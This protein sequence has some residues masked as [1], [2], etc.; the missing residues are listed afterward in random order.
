MSDHAS[1]THSPAVAALHLAQAAHT[2]GVPTYRALYERIRDGILSGK[3]APAAR[4]PSTRALA[5]ELGV[6]RGTVEAA[7]ERLVAEGFVIGR[8]AAGSRVN[9]QLDAARL[10]GAAKALPAPPGQAVN[11]AAG[12]PAIVENAPRAP[13]PAENPNHLPLNASGMPLPLQNGMPALDEFPRKL[14]ARLAAR[15]ARHLAPEGLH[16]QDATGWAPLREAIAGYLAIARGIRCEPGQIVVTA[17]YQGALTLI[18]RVLLRPGDAVWCED[19]GYFRAHEALRMAGAT[20]VPVPVDQQGLDVAAGEAIAPHA[21]LAVVTPSHQSPLS[22]T[23]PLARRLALLAWAQARDAWIIED[24]YD[25][26]FRYT[27]APLP[28]LKSLDGGERVLYAGS[29]SKV[30]FPGLR[31]GYL[32]VPPALCD[33]FAANAALAAPAQGWIE[34]AT[35]TDFITQGHFSRHIRRMRQLYGERRAALA[36][37][38]RTH[39]AGRI[40]L[41]QQ[42]GGMHLLGWLDPTRG[43]RDICRAALRHGL[44]PGALSFFRVARTMPP[45]LVMS[46]TNVSE[47]SAADVAQRLARAFDDDDRRRP[48][49]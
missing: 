37:A 20:L 34:Q 18:A 9:P 38:L 4:L 12:T 41:A 25:S 27:G 33:A 21:R 2:A 5:S 28:A 7:Y 22:V 44:A 43:D 1:H 15:H 3:L 30:L 19:P 46:F 40:E 14:W 11:G 42:A 26:E 47:S 45:A 17:G 24:D 6:A 48:A 39:L 29:F 16:Y 23:L 32:V 13:H 8:G 10:G 36:G 31:L 35:V 49:R